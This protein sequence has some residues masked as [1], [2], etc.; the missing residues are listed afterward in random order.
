MIQQE[1]EQMQCAIA[2]PRVV[3]KLFF[4]AEG[5]T[6][7]MVDELAARFPDSVPHNQPKDTLKM[8]VLLLLAIDLRL[9]RFVGAYRG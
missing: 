3:P 1:A 2:V 5:R 7:D 4:R 8:C 6:E 9:R